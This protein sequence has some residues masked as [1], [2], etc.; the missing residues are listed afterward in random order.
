MT[1][2]LPML[3]NVRSEVTTKSSIPSGMY[4]LKILKS[5][6]SSCIS[7]RARNVRLFQAAELCRNKRLKLLKQIKCIEANGFSS[8]ACN[9]CSSFS[10]PFPQR[11]HLPFYHRHSTGAQ[12]KTSDLDL[13]SMCESQRT[14]SKLSLRTDIHPTCSLSKG[15]QFRTTSTLLL[16]CCFQE[17]VTTC[18]PCSPQT[19]SAHI[20]VLLIHCLQCKMDF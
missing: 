11:T 17:S 15:R 9:I 7:G 2:F 6:T 20:H 5:D 19:H 14:T 10:L 13:I 1:K 16:C 4:H 12:L 8:L 18:Q 3:L